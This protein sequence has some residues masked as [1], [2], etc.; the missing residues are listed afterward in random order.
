M[1]SR[2]IPTIF[3]RW[4]VLVSE[5]TPAHARRDGFGVRGDGAEYRAVRCCDESG[6]GQ[7]ADAVGQGGAGV[8]G[9]VQDKNVTVPVEEL[10]YVGG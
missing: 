1:L 4:H 8:G 3:V 7:T 9:T 5:A 2:P 10:G 6:I